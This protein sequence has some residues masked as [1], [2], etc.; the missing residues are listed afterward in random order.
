[1]K[2]SYLLIA[3]S[4][5][6]ISFT[7]ISIK[8]TPASYL[9]S[10]LSIEDYQMFLKAKVVIVNK[11]SRKLTLEIEDQEKPPVTIQPKS[12][13]SIGLVKE[14]K[15]LTFIYRI[16]EYWADIVPVTQDRLLKQWKSKKPGP[17]TVVIT[18]SK[19]DLTT[20]KDSEK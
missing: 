12:S 13:K 9:T 8:A 4:C 11:L 15:T 5:I 16:N 20:T 18:I 10:G 7:S 19:K 1:M 17:N 3:L 2:S 6:T 14:H